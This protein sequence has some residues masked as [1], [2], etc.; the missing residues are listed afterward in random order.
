MIEWSFSWFITGLIGGVVLAIVKSLYSYGE[1]VDAIGRSYCDA[2]KALSEVPPTTLVPSVSP[3]WATR[4]G[5]SHNIQDAYGKPYPPE[6]P[7]PLPPVIKDVPS[8]G[9]TRIP[10]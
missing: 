3:D 1:S 9:Q 2:V 10:L 6:L 5:R 8:Q 7:A 4:K